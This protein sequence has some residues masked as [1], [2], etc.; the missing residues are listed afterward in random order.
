MKKNLKNKKGT[1]LWITGISG[2][3]KTTISKLIYKKFQKKCGPTII[4]QGD[5]LRKIFKFKDYS[6]LGRISNGLIFSDLIKKISD[7][8]IN[9]IISVIGMFDIIRNRNRKNI[10]NYIEVYIQCEISNVLK[11]TKKKHY[12]NKKNIVGIDIKPEF[13]KKPHIKIINNFKK[14]P[15]NMSEEILNKIDKNFT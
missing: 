12:K 13:P 15:K 9:V 3:G 6:K 7:Q 8:G 14:S 11:K 4:F 5:E 1:V 10:N 2:S